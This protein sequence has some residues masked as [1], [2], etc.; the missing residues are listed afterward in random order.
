[1]LAAAD[2]ADAV[3]VGAR[4]AVLRRADGTECRLHGGMGVLRVRT[5]QRMFPEV[6]SEIA[7]AVYA[8]QEAARKISLEIAAIFYAPEGDGSGPRDSM[9]LAGERVRGVRRRS[10]RPRRR[11][12]SC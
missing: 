7:G 11:R 1:M 5:L 3:V 2:A 9:V 8:F 10:A 4:G 6:A 12:G